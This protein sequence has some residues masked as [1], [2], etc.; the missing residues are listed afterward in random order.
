MGAQ[1]FDPHSEDLYESVSKNNCVCLTPL[2]PLQE[3]G[4]QNFSHLVLREEVKKRKFAKGNLVLGDSGDMHYSW[5]LVNFKRLRV[6]N[7]KVAG[8]SGGAETPAA[9]FFVPRSRLAQRCFKEARVG[10]K[11]GEGR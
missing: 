10:S 11:R 5:R 6:S 2:F 1:N 9:F 7:C 8:V 4:V 3:E